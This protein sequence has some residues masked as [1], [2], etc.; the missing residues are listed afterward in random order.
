MARQANV[1]TAGE[2]LAV[3]ETFVQPSARW[4]RRAIDVLAAMSFALFVAAVFFGVRGVFFND[5]LSHG[6]V[7]GRGSITWTL[8][9]SNGAIIVQRCLQTPPPARQW[10]WSIASFAPENAR[11]VRYTRADHRFSLYSKD[12]YGGGRTVISQAGAPPSFLAIIAAPLPLARLM[13]RRRAHRRAAGGCCAACGYDLRA[14]RERCPECGLVY[15]T[16]TSCP[17]T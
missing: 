12:L 9:S 17:T 4:R 15:V 1:K 13:A 3:S 11:A 7:V 10:G 16:G 8:A 2:G 14:S 5:Y 6:R